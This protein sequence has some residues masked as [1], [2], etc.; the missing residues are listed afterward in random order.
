MP[1]YDYACRSC[2]H[3]FEAFQSMND[4][5]LVKC[6]ECGRRT[7][8]RLVGTGAGILFKASGFYETDYKRAGKNSGGESSSSGDKKSGSDGSGTSKTPAAASSDGTS[9]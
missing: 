2:E 7:L 1:T 9:K 3:E 6:P 5:P 8:E 4:K